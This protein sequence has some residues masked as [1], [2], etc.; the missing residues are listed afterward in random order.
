MKR[1]EQLILLDKMLYEQ[2][3][4]SEKENTRKLKA[5]AE[6]AELELQ[7]RKRKAEEQWE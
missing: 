2:R 4:A 3:I 7:I 6:F 1:E 5:E